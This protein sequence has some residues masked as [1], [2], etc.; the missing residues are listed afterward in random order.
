MEINKLLTCLIT[1]LLAMVSFAFAL[2]KISTNAPAA[3]VKMAAPAVTTGISSVALVPL[4]S[5]APPVRLVGHC[6]SESN[7]CHMM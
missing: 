4:D 5:R 6:L 7:L 1:Y 3:H 2:L